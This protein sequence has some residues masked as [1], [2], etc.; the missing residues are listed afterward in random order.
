MQ[1]LAALW[2]HWRNDFALPERIHRLIARDKRFGSRDRRLY[3]ELIYTA[4]RYL[5]W[6]EPLIEAD[7]AKT[8][9]TVAW[10]AA[11]S[12]DTS[13]FRDALLDNW[14][15]C[16][17]G[18]DARARHLGQDPT[19][20]LPPWFR[21]ECPA[22]FAE[23]E[24]DCLL[25]RAPLWVRMQ[26]EHIDEV[27]A[28]FAAQG[29]S[30][31]PSMVLPAAFR[32]PGDVG[33]KATESFFAGRFEVQDLGS[34]MV[35]AAHAIAPGGR[36]LDACAGAGGKALHLARM[37]G[38]NGHVVA[39][40]IRPDALAELAERAHRA[41]LK[42]VSRS[43]EVPPG[44]FDGVLVDAPCSGSGTWRR[45]PHLKWI[46]TPA[47]VEAHARTQLELLQRFANL[48]RPGGQLIYATCSL[49]RTENEG[50]MT[51]FLASHPEFAAEPPAHDFGFACPGPGLTVLPAR[52]DTDGFFTCALRRR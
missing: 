46:T 35:L 37:L 48:V 36:W 24:L 49:N 26:T 39:H 8:L 7:E 28:D 29:W 9:Q 27:L 32:L 22:A 3:R 17:D 30:A 16:P 40:D 38:P 15:P 5:P 10:L 14:P 11:D 50:V 4:L 47:S 2:P 34:Q 41:Q 19:L 42:T 33:A 51:A 6:V 18:L 25:R 1:L 52:H 45:S 12:R 44:Q 21:D 23:A 43:T 31:T 20:L 13:R